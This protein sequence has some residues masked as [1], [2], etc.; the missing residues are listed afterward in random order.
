[1]ALLK[2][3]SDFCFFSILFYSFCRN[4]L[5]ISMIYK[6]LCS[7]CLFSPCLSLSPSNNP[8]S[9][10]KGQGAF[11]CGGLV[12][13]RN[14]KQMHTERVIVSFLD[15]EIFQQ[16]LNVFVAF[17]ECFYISIRLIQTNIHTF[18]YVI[19]DTVLKIY[20]ITQ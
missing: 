6:P 4:A 7:T 10:G 20:L 12:P 19:F 13:P 18:L 1:M 2:S 5:C 9:P 11:S 16:L 15:S 8:F 3:L 14:A 17:L